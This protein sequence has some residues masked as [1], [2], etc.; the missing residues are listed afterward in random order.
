VF[1]NKGQGDNFGFGSVRR[2]QRYLYAFL[3]GTL[4]EFARILEFQMPVPGSFPE[5][6]IID[7]S[8]RQDRLQIAIAA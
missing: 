7:F 6:Q 1:P 8:S 2:A 5:K 3:P 4:R